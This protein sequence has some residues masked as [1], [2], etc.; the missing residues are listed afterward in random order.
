MSLN[1]TEDAPK[2]LITLCE[3]LYDISFLWHFFSLKYH[4]FVIN[5]NND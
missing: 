3:T 5:G 2:Y 1:F 4:V